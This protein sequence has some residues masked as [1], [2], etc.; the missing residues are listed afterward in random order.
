MQIFYEFVGL[1]YGD[2]RFIPKSMNGLNSF[3]E[4]ISESNT[5]W[6]YFEYIQ[7]QIHHHYVFDMRWIQFKSQMD[8]GELSRKYAGCAAAVRTL[9]EMNLRLVDRRRDRFWDFECLVSW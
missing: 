3:D 5:S 1:F 4:I 6:K 2:L 9:D 7:P 8:C